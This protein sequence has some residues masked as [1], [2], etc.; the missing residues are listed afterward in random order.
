MTFDVQYNEIILADAGI[1]DGSGSA[2][3]TGSIRLSLDNDMQLSEFE[4]EL[5]YSPSFV[6]I[7]G[8]NP[9]DRVSYDSL[10]ING[11][12]LQLL[13]PVIE[14]GSGEFLELQLFN[15]VGVGTDISVKYKMALA[16]THDDK[17]V[18]ITFSNEANY[19]I[20]SVDQYYTIQPNNGVINGGASYQVSSINTVPISLS[21]IKFENTPN[22]TGCCALSPS[23]KNPRT[24]SPGDIFGGFPLPA[25]PEPDSGDFNT[26][27]QGSS[28]FFNSTSSS[29]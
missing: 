3:N 26:C 11:N 13:N 1:S 27:A 22:I 19:I 12:H 28:S 29:G 4:F 20:N 10:I 5:E 25:L 14:A 16:Y 9:I 23:R 8:A 15:N 21:V 17:E 6:E 18:G 24:V 2:Y 7:T